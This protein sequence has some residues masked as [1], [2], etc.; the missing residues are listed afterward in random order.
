L[1]ASVAVVYAATDA[2]SEATATDFERRTGGQDWVP[3]WAAGRHRELRFQR[4]TACKTWRH[5]PGPMCP[6][7]LSTEFEWAPAS[8]KATLL[9]WV[10]VHPPVLPAWKERTPFVVVLVQCEEG[11]RTMGNLLGATVDDLRMDMPMVVD[12]A[13][14]PDG[15]L[16]PQWR[17]A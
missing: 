9:S 8:G 7:C 15:D 1:I 10:V 14:S 5:P 13:P 17:L 2:M 6:K 16:V 12:F 11:P 3:F 4:C